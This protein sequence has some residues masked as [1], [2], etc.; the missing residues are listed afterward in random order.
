MVKS[1]YFTRFGAQDYQIFQLQDKSYVM[2][3]LVDDFED[4]NLSCCSNTSKGSPSRKSSDMAGS[5]TISTFAGFCITTAS[6]SD[7]SHDERRHYAEPTTRTHFLKAADGVCLVVLLDGR[8]RM[9]NE[10]GLEDMENVL[11]SL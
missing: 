4:E 2:V 7:R 6:D 5:S 11:P 8:G 1:A 9:V 10:I 3:R